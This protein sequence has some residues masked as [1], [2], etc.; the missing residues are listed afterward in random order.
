M[1]IGH[2]RI[3]TKVKLHVGFDRIWGCFFL[4]IVFIP[5]VNFGCFP[6]VSHTI[7]GTQL[8]YNLPRVQ[9]N[10]LTGNFFCDFDFFQFF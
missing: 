3:L 7:R 8:V 5:P 9:C 4:L 1:E 2:F 6:A 10:Q